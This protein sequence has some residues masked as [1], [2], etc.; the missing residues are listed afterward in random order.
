MG[1]GTGRRPLVEIVPNF[2]EGRRQDVI[3]AI[4]S[5]L[6]V[7]GVVL[8]NTQWD[9]EHNRL[10]CSL[11]GDPD[12]VRR[13][14]MAG[15]ARAVELID[16]E[17]HEG[18]HP[19]MGAVDVIPFLPVRDVDMQA[20]VEL[21]R[22]F[23]RELAETLDLPVYCYDQAA[24][25]P[26]RRSLADVRKGQY[27][28]LKADVAAGRRLPDFGPHEIGRAGAVA[29]GAR[30][31]LIAFNVYLTGTDEA[32]KAV[33]R[34]VRESG[35][36]LKNVRAVGFGV[37]ERGPG[38]VTVSM[39]LV[40]YE[41]T[42][43]YRAFELVR[44]E[45]A[46]YGMA[47]LSSE[48]VGL[49]P[50]AAVAETATHYLRLEGFDADAQVL[51]SVVARAEADGAGSTDALQSADGAGSTDA[52]GPADGAGS[53]DAPGPAD[54][55]GSTDA[56]GPRP[57][58]IADQTVDSFLARLASD[59]PT[60]GGGSA[61]AVAGAAGAALVAMVGRLTAGKKGYEAVDARMGKIAADADAA[62][63]ELLGLADRDAEAFDAVMAAFR[64]PKGTQEEKAERRAAVQRAFSGAAQ[65]PL[66]VARRAA[67]LLSLAEEV[68]R[69]GNANAASDGAAAAHL[70]AAA[71]R[72]ALANVEINAASITDEAE[73][74]ALRTEAAELDRSAGRALEAAV[75][76][77]HRRLDQA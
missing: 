37:P 22:D 14:A 65:V 70:L 77:F 40:D 25:V 6:Q 71:T 56:P 52:P 26:E 60:P 50:Q 75:E 34:R 13:S 41:Q 11:V 64:L 74:G 63:G 16:M 54:G 51:E 32:A 53:T 17:R 42:P 8:L 33:A 46:R 68:V 30:K 24:L 44:V 38:V 19:R 3:D 21:A 35:G 1:E 66:D 10:D 61:A 43:M 28:G 27:E 73:A 57:G 36:G 20:C 2:S 59:E 45:A 23:A 69:T 47:V 4:V 76:A 55:A 39:N 5:A 29:V 49:V 9:A 12:S 7:P 48:I 31:P 18:S 15:A 67:S 62:R 72:T 58:S